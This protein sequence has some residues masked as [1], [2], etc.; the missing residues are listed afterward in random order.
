VAGRLL[1]SRLTGRFGERRLLV[2]AILITAAGF[3]LYWSLASPWAAFLGLV[4]CGL[5]VCTFYPLGLSRALEAAG[6]QGAQGSSLA[7]LASGS[8]I[9]VAPL[10]LGALAD[11]WGLAAALFA[12]PGGLLVMVVLLFAKK[13]P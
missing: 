5:G 1:S 4:L 10:A 3:P 13:R 11:R 9:L 6:T 7:T 8:A 12:I 2:I